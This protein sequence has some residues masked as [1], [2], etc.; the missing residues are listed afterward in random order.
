MLDRRQ[1]LA[2][3]VAAGCSAVTPRLLAAESRPAE[4]ASARLI[5][6]WY[7]ENFPGERDRAVL[8]DRLSAAVPGFTPDGGGLSSPT[9]QAQISQ[10]CSDDFIRDDVI[11]VGGWLFART[12]LRLCALALA[13]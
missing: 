1:V 12:E 8:I 7:L 13:A 9:V 6:A 4:A 10:A 5:G 11:A 2:A 3:G